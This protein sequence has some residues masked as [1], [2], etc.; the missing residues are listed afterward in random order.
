VFGGQGDGISITLAAAA[1]IA[2]SG[3]YPPPL[4]GENLEKLNAQLGQRDVSV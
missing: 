2:L 1:I 3:L 4:I